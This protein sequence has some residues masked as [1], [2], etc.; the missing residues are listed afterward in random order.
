MRRL[1]PARQSC[2]AVGAPVS[3]TLAGNGVQSCDSSVANAR[4]ERS[5]V[6]RLRQREFRIAHKSFTINDLT[7]ARWPPSPRL[8][9]HL[10]RESS[11]PCKPVAD[12]SGTTPDGLQ[13]GLAKLKPAARAPVHPASGIENAGTFVQDHPAMCSA[14]PTPRWT[15][16]RGRGQA[17]RESSSSISINRAERVYRGSAPLM[18]P[19]CPGRTP[20]V[21]SLSSRPPAVRLF[22]NP[23][24]GGEPARIRPTTDDVQ[25]APEPRPF[26]ERTVSTNEPCPRTGRPGR[27]RQGPPAPI[28]SPIPVPSLAP[29]RSA[30]ASCWRRLSRGPCGQPR[31]RSRREG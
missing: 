25:L 19:A 9:P 31:R 27:A 13:P 23:Q 15:S 4:R 10:Q 5:S 29:Q 14:F 24:E 3:R 18:K 6:L 2:R 8:F 1:R 11:G 17:A 20:G 16:G 22:R 7:Q 30:L 26:N 21:G 12:E 28:D